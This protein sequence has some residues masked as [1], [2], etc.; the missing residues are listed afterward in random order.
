MIFSNIRSHDLDCL[1][2]FSC[3]CCRNCSHTCL[4]S[5]TYC[6]SCLPFLLACSSGPFPTVTFPNGSFR[7]HLVMR[8]RLSLRCNSPI[9]G[10]Q[11]PFPSPARCII[12]QSR[13]PL[14]PERRLE[15]SQLCRSCDGRP[16]T[17]C[18]TSTQKECGPT[19]PQSGSIVACT[20]WGT[21]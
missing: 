13:L 6:S 21:Q 18:G 4:K 15:L 17:T 10:K 1:S 11:L 5:S 2:F 9:F 12:G 19:Y 16:Y 20:S 8:H 7:V 14:T 3:L